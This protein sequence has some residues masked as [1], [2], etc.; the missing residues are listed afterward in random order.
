MH[1]PVSA[2]ADLALCSGAVYLYVGGAGL[3][4]V[5]KDAI[6]YLGYR[7]AVDTVIRLSPSE[8]YTAD[9]ASRERHASHLLPVCASEI[10][11]K[12][13]NRVTS[14]DEKLRV[15]LAKLDCLVLPEKCLCILFR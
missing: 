9:F 4:P 7:G 10:A 6:H 2:E 8:Q 12:L 14:A 11:E 13:G 5:Q 1:D 15:G 3:D